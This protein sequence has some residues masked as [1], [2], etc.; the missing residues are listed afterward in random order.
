MNS[1]DQAASH[2]EKLIQPSVA[3]RGGLIGAL[4]WPMRVLMRPFAKV[5]T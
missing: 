3:P 2:E 4:L 5:V 1:D